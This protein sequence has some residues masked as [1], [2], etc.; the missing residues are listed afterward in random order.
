MPYI[1]RVVV[2]WC[3]VVGF[4]TARGNA[5]QKINI[6]GKVIESSGT[7]ISG[8]TVKLAKAGLTVTTDR[9]GK[10]TLGG[11]TAPLCRPQGN[12]SAPASFVDTLTV[13]KTGYLDYVRGMTNTDIDGLVIRPARSDHP[14]MT[15]KHVYEIGTDFRFRFVHT[16]NPR[17]DKDAVA[18]DGLL[19][20]YRLRTWAIFNHDE[21]LQTRIRLTT[22]PRYYWR[23]DLDEPWQYDEALFDQFHVIWSNA[24]D[25]DMQMTVGRQDFRLGSGWLVRRGTPRDGSRTNFFDA[26]RLQYELSSGSALDLIYIENRANSSAYIR[27][28]NDQDRDLAPQDD[29]GFIAYLTGVEQDHRQLDSYFIYKNS[30][31]PTTSYGREGETYTF[32]IR[33]AQ[34]LLNDWNYQ[35]EFAPQFGH[36]GGKSLSAFATN[37]WLERQLKNEQNTRLR[38]GYEYLS[39]DDDP[40]RHFDKLWGRATQWSELYNGGI[41]SIDGR[42]KDSSNLHR[43]WAD[44]TLDPS[45]RTEL[46]SGYHLIFAD[47]N[48]NTAGTDGLSK[49]GCFKGQLLT[50]QFTF[51]Q[52]KHIRHRALLEF[53]VPGDYYNSDRNDPALFARYELYFTW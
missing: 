42:T 30:H 17:L 32:G 34:D 25:L 6:S 43:I 50:S 47:E 28:F 10:F 11:G 52:S 8:A 14:K 46:S 40:D 5:S 19:Q 12:K 39:G 23:P 36:N 27:P 41:D 20:R 44:W 35:L 7:P 37:N 24:F 13:S 33:Y 4:V 29:R 53:F 22:E 21:N 16:L 9:D 18:S 3:A 49:S 38:F 1:F 2:I 26:I 31:D 45:A 51:A 15:Q 48:I